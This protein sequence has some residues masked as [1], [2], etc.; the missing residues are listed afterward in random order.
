MNNP[1]SPEGTPPGGPR[2]QPGDLVRV[3]PEYGSP[4]DP[5][6]PH[7]RLTFLALLDEEDEGLYRSVPVR[8][9]DGFRHIVWVRPEQLELVQRGDQ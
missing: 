3:W 2:P 7:Q 4:G 6:W 8:P 9:V 5:E 1:Q